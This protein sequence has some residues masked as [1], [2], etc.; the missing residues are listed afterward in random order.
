MYLI[1]GASSF[2]G[3]HLYEY[4]KSNEAD[5]L[6]TYYIHPEYEE[7]VKFDLCTDTIGSICDKY[8]GGRLPDAVIIC[9]ANTSIDNCKSNEEKSSQLN[10]EGT[11]RILDEINRNEIK[12][13]FLSSE[14]VF[15]GKRGMYGEN[16]TPNPV[17]VYGKQ[18]LLIE[19]YI[20]QNMKNYII[21]WIS[22]AV[23]SVFGE[24]DIFH[25]FYQKIIQ[26]QE[27]ACLKNQ[28]FCLTE[29]NDIAQVMIKAVKMDVRGLYHVSSSNYVSR[30]QLAQLYSRAVFGAEYE[31]IRE[32]EYEELPFV[33]NRHVQAGLRG[34]KI[35]DLLHFKYMSMEEILQK[36]RETLPGI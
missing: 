30:Y 32:M 22:R 8:T 6:G 34:N 15:D 31:R 26:K 27:I 7:W 20:V 16:D 23:G 18:K 21:F 10:V 4:C 3:R 25:E 12:S 33:D 5:V 36:Y 17:T 9:G 11:K 2:I 35:A 24:K 14:A 1:I 29:V 28:S 13:V 19:E